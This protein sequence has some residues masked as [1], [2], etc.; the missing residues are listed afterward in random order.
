M[1]VHPQVPTV[2]SPISTADLADSQPHASSFN[3]A[4][5]P[6]TTGSCL[7]VGRIRH[8]R[9]RPVAR[10]FQYSL[11][12]TLIDLDELDSLFRFPLLFSQSRMSAIQFRRTDH[13]GDA[14]QPLSDCVRELV[15]E[16]IGIETIGKVRLLTHLR[17]FG[18]VFNPV[19]FYYCYD[20]NDQSL[21]AV[22][23]EVTN[24]PW[25]ERHC[26][27]IPW[28][29]GQETN[30]TQY[31]CEKKLHV[32]PFMHMD[33]DYRWRISAP[34]ERLSVH[35]ENHD[36]DGCVF[37][38]TLSLSRRKLTVARLLLTV[39]RFP[40]MTMQVFVA[41]Y[42]QAVRIWFAKVPFVPHPHRR[43]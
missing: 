10:E 24:T 38:A 43:N 35:I 42:W 32:S 3:T 17:M 23:A 20:A 5:V 7:Y 9:H 27:V 13:F 11:Y 34:E 16:Q 18:F 14:K 4:T 30:G 33:I 29:V 12:L 40:W 39:I 31:E 6:S 26:Y 21:V 1:M 8:R 28:N 37:D 22:V 36:Q 41:I 2:E 19:S 25:S 15:R